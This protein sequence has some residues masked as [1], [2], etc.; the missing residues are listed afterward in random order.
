MEATNQTMLGIQNIFKLLCKVIVK[1]QKLYFRM[2]ENVEGKF[3]GHVYD[4]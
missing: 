2:H 4:T 3:L 1:I